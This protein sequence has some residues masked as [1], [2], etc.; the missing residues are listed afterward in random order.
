MKLPVL[1]G[2]TVIG[3]LGRIGFLHVDQHGS[4]VILARTEATG[5][6]KVVVPL[7]HE[8]AKGTLLSI[9]K[10]AGM[11]RNEFLALFK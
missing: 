9:M 2:K 5:R 3:A 11:S 1:S 7:H 8:L 10:Q 4:H 6:R